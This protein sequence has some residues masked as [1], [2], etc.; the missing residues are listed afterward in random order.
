[1]QKIYSTIAVLAISA[2]ALISSC[3]KKNDGGVKPVSPDAVV[4]VNESVNKTN[5]DTLYVKRDK[6]TATIQVNAVSTINSDMQRIYILKKTRSITSTSDYVP[7]NGGVNFKKDDDDYYY[8][9]IPTDQ[10]NNTSITLTVTLNA[11]NSTAVFDEYYFVF[12]DAPADGGSGGPSAIFVGPA[13]IFIYYGLLSETKGHKLNNMKGTNSGAFNLVDLKNEPASAIAGYKD[14][15]DADS[16]TA[17]W[18]KSF[19]S[20][21]ESMFVKL[22]NSFDYM[23]ATDLSIVDAYAAGNAKDA[24]L[25]VATGDMFVAKLRGLNSYTLIKVT[26]ISEENNGTGTGKNNEYMQ[27]SVKK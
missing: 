9:E 18:D 8:Y 3:S 23:N 12:T 19:T 5:A 6:L 26:S 20:G 15:I 13:K 21:N 4:S 22:P 11:N 25:N 2:L 7:Y 17:A 14:M 1:M 10:R 16:S 27:F 24:Q